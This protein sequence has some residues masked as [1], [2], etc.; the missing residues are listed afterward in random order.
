MS[1]PRLHH[2]SAARGMLEHDHVLCRRSPK[3]GIVSTK[4]ALSQGRVL[5][6]VFAA[7]GR[8]FF[9]IASQF[10]AG[11]VEN[12]SGQIGQVQPD[13]NHDGAPHSPSRHTTWSIR[14]PAR[15]RQGPVTTHAR[16]LTAAPVGRGRTL[17]ARCR[18]PSMPA[19]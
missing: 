14:P 17:G 18:A 9:F 13:R 7:N 1:V 10:E 11:D 5:T 12:P 8:P 15:R 16:W 2:E 4:E 6:W 19:F 3:G